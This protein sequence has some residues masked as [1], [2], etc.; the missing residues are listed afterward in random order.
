[1]LIRKGNSKGE[2][3]ETSYVFSV[4]DA[5]IVLSLQLNYWQEK[6][7]AEAKVIA[8]TLNGEKV[9]AQGSYTLYKL[10]EKK[11]P[12]TGSIT[13]ECLQESDI[14]TL[15]LTS[16]LDGSEKRESKSRR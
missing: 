10:T 15:S 9:K 1:M 4:G 16:Q 11:E 14:R 8:Q 2:T 3:Q 13:Y 5:G 6:G 12:N 7:K